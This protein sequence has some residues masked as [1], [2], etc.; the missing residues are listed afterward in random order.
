MSTIRNREAIMEERQRITDCFWLLLL[1][2][3]LLP[4]FAVF[5]NYALRDEISWLLEAGRRLIEGGSF[6][7]DA[8]EL[9][10]PLSTIIYMP[11][12]FAEKITGVPLHYAY[13][14]YILFLIFLS[15]FFISV[16]IKKY[17][18]LSDGESKAFISGYVFS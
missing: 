17:D 6:Y 11:A 8:Y 2:L 5:S 15:A 1:C 10:P 9:N 13:F 3:L 7:K 16:I 12:I 4:W 18:F 14:G